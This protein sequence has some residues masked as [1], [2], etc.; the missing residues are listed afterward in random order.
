[1]TWQGAAR[2]LALASFLTVVVFFFS[3]FVSLVFSSLT[4]A[5]SSASMA[6]SSWVLVFLMAFLTA[7]RALV[8]WATSALRLWQ[9]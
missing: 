5:W 4:L 6:C 1:M 8:R 3:S 7:L 9:S 2:F